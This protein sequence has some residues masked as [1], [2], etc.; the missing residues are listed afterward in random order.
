M[1]IILGTA[2][3]IDHGKTTLVKA[4]TGINCDR[5]SEER[6]RG[7]TIELG[8]AFLDL[9]D[10]RLGIVDVPGHERFVKNMVAGAVGIDMVML[11]VAADEGVMPQ[12]R[13]HLD[14]CSLLG[15]KIGLVALTKTDMID[16]PEWLELAKEDVREALKGS[17][18]EQAP[19]LPV[20]AQSGQGL[21][22]L[23][24]EILDMAGSFCV[25]RRSDLFR[26]AIDRVFTMR[27]YGTVVTGTSFSGQLQAGDEIMVYPQQKA[28]KVR[29]L[30]VHGEICQQA[31]AGLRTAVNLTGF[32]VADLERGQVLAHPNTLF[33]ATTWNLHLRCLQSAR[34]GIK[35]RREIHFYHGTKEILARIYLLDRDVLEPGENCVCQVRFPS[36]MVGAFGDAFLVRALSPLQTLAGGTVIDPMAQKI[37]RFS[38]QVEK[39]RQI[40]RARAEELV[41][42]Q[43]DLAGKQG[44]SFDELRLLTD[45][46]DQA[47]EKLLN[48]L[49]SRGQAFSLSKKDRL[50]VSAE[51]VTQLETSFLEALQQFHKNNPLRHGISRSELESG[52]GKN[53]PSRLF[54]FLV[55]RLL[56]TQKI[57]FTQEVLCLRGHI[58]SLAADTATLQAN[59]LNIYTQ[60]GTEP[61]KIKEAAE[62]LS[63]SINEVMP[64]IQLLLSQGELV[65]VNAEFLFSKAAIAQLIQQI[66]TF[67]ADNK[68]LNPGEFRD[69]TGLSR[70]Y[71]IPILE[72]LDSAKIT[73]RVGDKRHL[74]GTR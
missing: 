61:P 12:T 52:W 73:V 18:L 15:V 64:V 69:L 58:I 19:I 33:P 1:P 6:K 32:E 59:I 25:R 28:S 67:F 3:H 51:Q 70:K 46:E 9:G 21:D 40:A 62:K 7:I 30:Q 35:H 48:N 41:Q 43:L 44:R 26:L 42:A 56:K 50:Y 74:R 16:D 53:I 10:L 17:F 49:G 4:L 5:L 36:P 60:A 14:I 37:K 71:A 39:L 27:G 66:H 2:G 54:H 8:F 11:V 57:D 72:Y 45:M 29:T 22:A 24:A 63:V 13:E 31:G 47:L 20:S 55:E 65:K 68:T 34:K 38:S 23:R